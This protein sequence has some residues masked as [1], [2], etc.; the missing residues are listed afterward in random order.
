M[1]IPPSSVQPLKGWPR[2]KRFALRGLRA[3]LVTVLIVPP[4][5]LMLYVVIPPPVTP[6][7]IQRSFE[8]QGID[9]TWKSLDQ[10]SPHLAQA[11]IASE[12]NLF[13]QHQGFDLAAFSRALEHWWDGKA[14]R[15]GSTVSQQTAKNLFLLPTKTAVRKGL[16]AYATVWLEI[17]WSKPRILETYLNI[18]EWGPGIYGAEAAAQKYFGIPASRLSPAQAAR[19]AAVLP[20]PL[21]WSAARPSSFVNR[22]A[23]IIQKRIGQLPPALL[24]CSRY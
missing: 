5:A 8:G 19:L 10:I 15:G 7:M 2:F 17:L 11:V 4:L 9:K 20:N 12:D 21:S 18:A 16:E 14:R 6:L 3:V 13:C 24:E 1:T 23:T 22:R